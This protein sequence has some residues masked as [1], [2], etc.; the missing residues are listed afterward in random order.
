MAENPWDAVSRPAPKTPAPNP[1]L[2]KY[3]RIRST[4]AI[5]KIAD[6]EQ[7]R[8]AYQR[9]DADPRVQRLRKLAGLA[10]VSTRQ[11]E[12]RAVAKKS[13]GERYKEAGA[14]V[15]KKASPLQSII[16]AASRGFLF[17]VPQYA[18]AALLNVAPSALTGIPKDAT[19][20]NILQTIQGRDRAAVA[21][22]PWFGVPTEI[23]TSYIGGGAA[24]RAVGAGGARLAASGAPI[25]APLGRAIQGATQ[26]KQGQRLKNTAKIVGAGTAGGAAQA[27]GVGD[28][29]GQGALYGGGGA[30]LLGGAVGGYK[31]AR[32][33]LGFEPVTQILSRYVK[34][35][36]SEI[37]RELDDRAAQGLNS[38][39]YEVLP[40]PDR[41]ALD[42]AIARMPARARERL[43][44]A[45]NQRAQSIT[46]ETSNR[47]QQI[48]RPYGPDR[49]RSQI[50]ADL[51]ASRGIGELPTEA[52]RQLAERAGRSPLDMREVRQTEARNIMRPFEDI[53]VA[54]QFDEILP[55]ANP[56]TGAQAD[57]QV[58]E[59][60]RG[61]AGPI[62]RRA[63][64]PEGLTV[65]DITDMA[66]N[67]RKNMQLPQGVRDR[68]LA[69]LDNVLERVSPEAA[70]ASRRMTTAWAARSR[71][72]E[73]VA[74]GAKTRRRV[75]VPD[76]GDVA[77]Q[78][79]LNAYDTP[80][81]TTGRRLGQAQQL[82]RDILA[83]PRQAVRS[84]D[85]LASNPS[86]QRAISE[87][88]GNDAG[89]QIAEVARMQA[90]SAQRLSG[91]DKETAQRGG[92]SLT[93]LQNL[94]MLGPS[95]LPVTKIRAV[96]GLIRGSFGIPDRQAENIVEMLFSQNPTQISRAIRALGQFGDD[97]I[98]VIRSINRDFTVGRVTSGLSSEDQSISD[99][100]IDD[101][102]LDED[103][104]GENEPPED[105]QIPDDSWDAVSRL[106][107]GRSIVEKLFPGVE[108]TDDIRDP[109]S[110]LG[111]ANPSSHHN[112][113]ENA[114]DVRPISGMTFD[115][116]IQKIRDEG[117]EI[118]EAR[119]E[120]NNPSGHATGPH[121]HVVLA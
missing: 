95:T 25:I 27:A 20:N 101:E 107:Q 76:E 46:E 59:A 8:I 82:E 29:V 116:F 11:G 28:D 83:T 119:D 49:A 66:S 50:A 113:S 99:T 115:Q 7:R 18:Q 87:N 19:Y 26:L 98:R 74:E 118:I 97:G 24:V 21:A 51:A 68:A 85:Q 73:G 100:T 58:A 81:G 112:A 117:Y 56:V 63:G 53:P 94:M 23:G 39:I 3:N 34:T 102:T 12:V 32:D 40:F 67:I 80:E 77:A 79:A 41:Q 69:H 121:W 36:I 106:P 52:E 103:I 22:N 108:V 6:P 84:I 37:Q 72:R 109:A 33:L 15:G 31:A 114:V 43:A 1:Y 104:A 120:V 9:F 5:S 47:V 93:L 89:E 62:R 71:M 60:I 42:D 17:G 35:P 38:T 55:D 57:D 64:D 91:L 70:D 61:A 2:E 78:K 90:R 4:G 111:R 86:A 48:I 13:A 44:A 54:Q 96:A 16:A 110:D 45:V 105:E 65:S 14:K 30:A 92:D 10:P 75:D 88:L